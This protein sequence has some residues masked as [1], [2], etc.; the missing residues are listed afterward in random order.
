[1][2]RTW[3]KANGT[4]L[5][6]AKAIDVYVGHERPGYAKEVPPPNAPWPSGLKQELENLDNGKTKDLPRLA[7]LTIGARVVLHKS[8]QFVLLGV[9]NNSDGIIHGIELDPR[10]ETA[11]AGRS[12]VHLRHPPLRILVYIHTADEA[13]LQLDGFPRGVIAIAPREKSFSIKCVGNR[14]F[15]FK[16]QQV[17]FT[18]GCL[19]SVYRS[20]GQTLRKII[21]D[22]RRPPGSKLDTAAVY[23][24][25]SRATGLDDI[26]M[27]FPITLED[28]NRPR[29]QDV[30]AI[31]SY[32]RRLDGASLALF[33]ETPA[34]FT[35]AS[36]SLDAVDDVG[37]KTSKKQR[38]KITGRHGRGATRRVAHLIPNDD[39]NCFFNS[40]LALSLAGWD[41]Q[42]LTDPSKGTPAASTF[43]S[44]LQ[45]LR[46]CMFDGSAV[47]PN[48]QAA[49]RD[50]RNFIFA[51]SSLPSAARRWAQSLA[52]SRASLRLVHNMIRSYGRKMFTINEVSS[53]PAM[54]SA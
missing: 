34:T 40:A 13:G 7:C 49:A 24:A 22:I 53:R 33:L 21:L 43:F 5:F 45:L 48:V 50:S 8:P 14:I 20:Q 16:R 1:M 9:C 11:T 35:P 52:F 31:V 44:A 37:P 46:D 38:R 54:T 18:A 26:N 4:P 32:L 42:I 27:L 28:L 3:S 12:I 15:T 39:N 2:M 23:V 10:E 19:S 51:N 6:I 30:V 25:L 17:P 47:P 29:N 36:A 41:A